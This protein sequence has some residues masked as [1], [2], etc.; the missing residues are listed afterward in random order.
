MDKAIDNFNESLKI[1]KKLNAPF[2]LAITLFEFGSLYEEK[3]DLA[4][5]KKYYQEVYSIY[6][7]TG[8]VIPNRLESKLLEF[9]G[10]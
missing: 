9:N 4:N 8:Q 10:G 1:V 5:A 2:Y 3:G 7:E 6:Q